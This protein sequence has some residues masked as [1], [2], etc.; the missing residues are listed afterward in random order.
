MRRRNLAQLCW[1]HVVLRVHVKGVVQ[2]IVLVEIIGHVFALIHEVVAGE[3]RW[4][5]VVIF[6]LAVGKEILVILGV[7]VEAGFVGV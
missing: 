6:E 3:R 7:I 4:V 5:Q 1:I 2:G